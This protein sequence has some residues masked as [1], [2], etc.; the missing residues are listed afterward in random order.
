KKESCLQDS[1]PATGRF[2]DIIPLR[3]SAILPGGLFNLQENS[4]KFPVNQKM[5]LRRGSFLCIKVIL[6]FVFLSNF[7]AC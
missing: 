6:T 1:P 7:T 2:S 5:T 3:R 4:T